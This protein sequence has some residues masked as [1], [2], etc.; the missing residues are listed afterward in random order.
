MFAAHWACKTSGLIWSPRWWWGGG[1]VMWDHVFPLLI[2]KRLVLVSFV[3]AQHTGPI[4]LTTALYTRM[5]RGEKKRPSEEG[6]SEWSGTLHEI[7]VAMR[8]R[9]PSSSDF[10]PTTLMPRELGKVGRQVVAGWSMATAL[11]W[12]WNE[13]KRDVRIS[14]FGFRYVTHSKTPTTATEWLS[15]TVVNFLFCFLDR[16]FLLYSGRKNIDALLCLIEHGYL[17]AITL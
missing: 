15:N 7:P 16:L 11:Q 6:R 17:L 3:R 13:R 1:G 8:M 5:F 10:R 12:Q 14:P 9:T 2:S 4:A